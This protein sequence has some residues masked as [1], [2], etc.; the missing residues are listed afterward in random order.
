M[1]WVIHLRDSIM[2]KSILL[3]LI[4]GLTLNGNCNWQNIPNSLGNT[5]IIGFAGDSLGLALASHSIYKTLDGSTFENQILSEQNLNAIAYYNHQY[6]IVGDSGT[7]LS[8][9]D[10]VQWNTQ[11]SPSSVT[12]RG[13]WADSSGWVS[14]G[15]SMTILHSKDGLQWQQLYGHQNDTLFTVHSHANDW[16]AAGSGGTV[17]RSGDLQNWQKTII[18]AG[19]RYT[20]SLWDGNQFLLGGYH[21][22]AYNCYGI[23]RK[24]SLNLWPQ[25]F[26]GSTKEIILGLAQ[27]QGH[28]LAFGYSGT[29]YQ[30]NDNKGWDK[31]IV[32]TTQQILT[33]ASFHQNEWLFA[34]AGILFA[35]STTSPIQGQ[36][37]QWSLYGNQLLLQNLNEPFQIWTSKGQMVYAQSE[38]H[39]GPILIPLSW[40]NGNYHLVFAHSREQITLP[41]T[42]P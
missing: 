33:F 4:T 17:L 24:D 26:D 15:D 3:A 9:R 30:S 42:R 40:A 11:Q 32:P 28:T 36:G 35:H 23:I 39:S 27:S 20:T 37:V 8:S 41:L 21:L 38:V 6:I 14:V 1:P 12:L 5:K 29:L 10:G 18:D 7:I 2:K 22:W 25:I 13:I 19:D 16:I 31:Q 34:S